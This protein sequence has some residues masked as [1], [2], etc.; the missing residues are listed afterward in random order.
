M[1]AVILPAMTYGTETWALRKLQDKKL[2]VA[3]R[4]MVRLLLNITKRGKIRNEVIRSKI[5]VK[6]IIERVRRVRGQWAG[7]NRMS[8]T[9][10]A[11]ITSEVTPRE[12]KRV[13]EK[14]KRRWRDKI[15]EVSSSQWMRVAQDRSMWFE[16]WRSSASSGMN[17]EDDGDDDDW[18]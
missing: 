8:N 1:V 13:R 12:G 16:L 9:R 15:K 7:Q 5:G 18:S 4:S 14:P 17:G 6:D 3:Q 10:W 11:K 2:A